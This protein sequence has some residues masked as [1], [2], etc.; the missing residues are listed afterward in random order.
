VS[1]YRLIRDPA[2]DLRPADLLPADQPLK[3]WPPLRRWRFNA[4]LRALVFWGLMLGVVMTAGTVVVITALASGVLDGL[5]GSATQSDLAEQL[6]DGVS[7]NWLMAIELVAAIVA[8]LVLTAGMEGRGWPMELSWRRIG[9]ALKG[10]ALGIVAI[11]LVVGLLAAAGCY[12]IEGFNWDYSPW[13]AL[14]TV[15]L[16]AGVA[17]ELM[18]RG[19][20]FRLLEDTFGSLAAIIAS[21]AVFGL[22]HIGN[23]DGTLLGGVGIAIEALIFPAIYMATRS[24][25]W[26]MGLHFAWNVAQGPIWGSVVSG[27]GQVES[28]VVAEWS[29]P[30]WLTGG[31]FGIEASVVAMAVL[32]VFSLWL[33]ARVHGDIGFVRPTWRRRRLLEAAQAES[34]P[35]PWPGPGPAPA[36]PAPPGPAGGIV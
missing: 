23:P 4:G 13:R 29:G 19:A 8:Y 1:L 14:F 15:G 12:R 34:A 25:W 9:G 32:G 16:V 30:E 31:A 36:A 33:L 28:W 27:T 2:A 17:E 26:L 18:F 3:P 22:I 10:M 24:L 7:M 6:V 21:S 5:D 35:S 20:L 11:S